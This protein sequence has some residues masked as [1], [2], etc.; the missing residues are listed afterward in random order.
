M[1]PCAEPPP[2][3]DPREDASWF[4]RLPS[5]HQA[6][7]RA[8][9][10]RA[11][12]RWSELER[13]ERRSFRRC[14]LEGA[15]VFAGGHVLGGCGGFGMFVL[16]LVVGALVGLAWWMLEAEQLLAPI[17][18]MPAFFALYLVATVARMSPDL[19][20]GFLFFRLAGAC[21]SIGGVSSW[22]ARE[23]H[24]RVIE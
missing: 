22:L 1:R 17:V 9:W 4:Q 2:E 13:R 15:L 11:R 19:A 10:S 14:L 5:G 12:E 8:D 23:R 21:F 20:T 3:R 16:A 6:Q 24:L 18:A 7:F